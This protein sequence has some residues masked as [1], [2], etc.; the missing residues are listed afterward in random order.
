MKR[1]LNPELNLEPGLRD[2]VCC[3]DLVGARCTKL[4][5]SWFSRVACVGDC[6]SAC[7]PTN[8]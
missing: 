1:W 6:V 3:A 8:S 7:L 4:Y 5:I 2:E